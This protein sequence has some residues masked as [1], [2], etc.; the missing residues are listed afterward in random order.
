VAMTAELHT[1]HSGEAGGR[2]GTQCA[3][4]LRY[5]FRVGAAAADHV[6]A[7]VTDDLNDRLSLCHLLEKAL[8]R[9]ILDI[10]VSDVEPVRPELG[11]RVRPRPMPEAAIK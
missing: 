11:S 5:V 7:L 3:T 1:D 2:T 10:A 4:R 9:D 8:V 6:P